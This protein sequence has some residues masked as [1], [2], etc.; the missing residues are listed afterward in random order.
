MPTVSDC[1]G[2]TLKLNNC[3]SVP[4]NAFFVL[5]IENRTWLLLIYSLLPVIDL[6]EVFAA[7]SSCY[8]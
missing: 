2:Q 3:P 7:R 4:E 5:E 6:R 1:Q 8:G